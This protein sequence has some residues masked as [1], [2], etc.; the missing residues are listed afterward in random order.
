KGA[1]PVDEALAVAKQIAEALEEA[2]EH[3]VI[4]RDLKPANIKLSQDGRVKVLDFGL[5]KALE[6][7]ATDPDLSMS[8]TALGGVTMHGVILGTAAYMSPEQARGMPMDKR[9][10]IWAFGCVLEMLTGRGAFVRETV[11][12]TLAAILDQEA[13]WG[14]LPTA[15]PAGV[16]R[17]L[18]RCLSKEPSRR[19]HAIADGRIEIDE[20]ARDA[21]MGRMPLCG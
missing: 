10:D 7:D 9:A 8:P 15:T 5:A 21:G 1:L 6:S 3:G 20:Q 2:H 16:R 12:D 13:D 11:A 18:R 19:L 4:H 14:Q 17:L